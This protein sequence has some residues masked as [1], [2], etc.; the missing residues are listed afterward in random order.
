MSA[1]QTIKKT[2]KELYKHIYAVILASFAW[3]I[4]GGGLILTSIVGIQTGFLLPL[5]IALLL[6]GPVTAGSFYVT[7]RLVNY[8]RVRIR[9]FFIGV[10]KYFLPS[11]GIFLMW[12][13]MLVII[14]V[15]FNFFLTSQYK[16]LNLLSAFWVYVLIF[17]TMVTIYILPLLIE[18]DRQEEDY[19]LKEL[20]KHALILTLDELKYTFFIF[21]NIFI[22]GSLTSIV[23]IALP[24]LF[25]GGISLAANN[26]TVNLLVKYDIKPDMNGPYDFQ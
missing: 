3:F 10:K 16:I 15:D 2:Y 21:V 5:V 17:L 26:A 7:N 8:E 22:F 25:M 9:D 6:L 1:W 11:L 18:Y 20:G 13:I 4:I 19:S 12:T 23:F 14:G 24:I